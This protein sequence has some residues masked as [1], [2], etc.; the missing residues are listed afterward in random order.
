MAEHVGAIRVGW[1][2]VLWMVS[3]TVCT[4]SAAADATDR[5]RVALLQSS[6]SEAG[7]EAARGP[8]VDSVL[9]AELDKLGAVNVTAS[10]GVDLDGLQLVLDC[11]GETPQCLRAVTN[12]V[13]VDGIVAPFIV[14][15]GDEVVLSILYY[16]AR[17]AGALKRVTHRERG[18]QLTSVT[19]DAVPALLRELFD[20]KEPV[21][22]AAP[23]A[24]LATPAPAPAAPP[25]E[26]STTEAHRAWPV[27]PTLVA[28]VGVL[29][30]GVG[31][32]FGVMA[33]STESDYG[34][35]PVTSEAEAS[36]ANDKRKAGQSQALIATIG[37]GAGAALAAVGGVWL[38]LALS[39]DSDPETTAQLMPYVGTSSVG[40]MWVGRTGGL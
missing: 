6:T 24:E 31:A 17:G 33:S 36:A 21:A 1:M 20:I 19:F 35:L 11:V 5:P 7:A 30:V 25:T 12:Q 23:S 3:S 40:L 13:G 4:Q 38:A 8:A 18:V 28:G 2:C 27:A 15:T 10:P 32:V 14:R 29:M 37:L 16:D 22:Q 9:H 34:K 39:D 26:P